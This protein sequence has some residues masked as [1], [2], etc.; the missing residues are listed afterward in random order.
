M[1]GLR[2]ILVGLGARSR[3]WRRVIARDPRL[4]VVGLVETSPAALADA[5]AA[6][7]AA[8][9][10]ATLAEVAAL[11]PAEA[12]L[13][14]TPPGGREDQIAA[15]C[16]H[17]LAILA[18]KPL[19]DS[20][21]AAEAHVAAAAAVGVPLS[22]GLNFR[23]LPVTVALKQ[24]W[25]SLGPPE[26]GRFLYE[27]WRDGRQTHLN[28]YPL[29]MPQPMLWEQSIHHFDLMRHV[30]GAEPVRITARTWNPS[31][32][33]YAGDAN[34]AALITFEGGIEVTYQGTWAGAR[35]ELAFNWRTDCARGVAVQA[36]MFGGLSWALRDD[37]APTP[38][39]LPPHE[40]WVDDAAALLEAFVAHLLHGAPL[41]CP[42][43]DHLK[44]LRMV[45]AC[46]RSAATG[47][48]V[49][50]GVPAA[51]PAAG[52]AVPTA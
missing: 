16:A 6:Y 46:I 21:G 42:G 12:V 7:P 35:N 14:I 40:L 44:S 43:T 3:T 34:V 50:P 23:Y 5:A 8:A 47:H 1:T 41:P 33:M 9:T 19:A 28:R 49:D 15:A 22:V 25:A 30:Y 39:T 20:V 45:E 51:A 18:E 32:S 4:E 52:I 36:D 11:A 27:R 24:M 17:R 13:L 29:T 38:V 26:F 2:L 37:P 48:A 10:G 31:W